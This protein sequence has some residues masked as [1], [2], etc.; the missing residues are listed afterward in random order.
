MSQTDAYLNAGYS[1]TRA[2][3]TVCASDLLTKPNVSSFLDTHRNKQLATVESQLLSKAEKRQILA[4]FARAQLTDL[5]DDNGNIKL[6]KTSSKALKEYYK[7]VRL[8]RDGNPITTSSIK[9]IDPISAIMEDNKMTGDYAPSKSINAQVSFN[10][11]MVEKPIVEI[12]D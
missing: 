4:S 6:D 2:M 5:I 1:T 9:L 3:A 12:E 11:K 10:V 7:K 8:D